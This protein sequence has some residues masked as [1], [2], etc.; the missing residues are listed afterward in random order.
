MGLGAS[1]T[2]LHTSF[3]AELDQ[4]LGLPKRIPSCALLPIGWPLGKYGRPPR[5]SVDEKLSFER[6]DFEIEPR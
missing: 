4:Y 3:R 5:D 6:F 2:T 1:L